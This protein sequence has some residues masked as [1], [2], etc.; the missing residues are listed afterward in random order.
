MVSYPL[1]TCIAIADLSTQCTQFDFS[2]YASSLQISSNSL[3]KEFIK[4]NIR[5]TYNRTS[6]SPDINILGNIQN[7]I[8]KN[9]TCYNAVI[10]A[11][12]YIFSNSQTNIESISVDLVFSDITSARIQQGYS[13]TFITNTTGIL[14]R[15]GNP[16]YQNGKKLITGIMASA[17]EIKYYDNG[18]QIPGINSD[19]SCGIETLADS[20]Y[21]VFGQNIIASCYVEFNYAELGARCNSSLLQPALFFDNSLLTLIGKYGYINYTYIDDWVLITNGTSFTIRNFNY[22]TGACSLDTMLAYYITYVNI[23]NAQNPQ[24]KI[25]YVQRDFGLGTWQYKKNDKTQSQRFFFT[26]SINFIE[27]PNSIY[28]Y[29]PPAPNPLPVMPDDIMYPFKISKGVSLCILLF[30]MFVF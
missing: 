30:Q 21:L 15:S 14:N 13:V 16:G 22:E 18:F 11:Q 20:Q 19:G 2:R 23:G 7:S 8:Y 1:V 12:Y 6:N 9:G 3:K 26:L 29:F 28:E 24:N 27:Y 17:T 5:N 4:V 25:I 10:E